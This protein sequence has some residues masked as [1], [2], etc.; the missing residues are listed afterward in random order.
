MCIEEV[1][2]RHFRFFT[3][4]MNLSKVKESVL[5]L[6]QAHHDADGRG[7]DSYCPSLS[8][9]AMAEGKLLA[10]LAELRRSEVV[11]RSWSKPILEGSIRRLFNLAL[12][13]EDGTAFGLGFA[14]KGMPA[15]TPF[16]ITTA[17]VLDGLNRVLSEVDDSDAIRG[18]VREATRWLTSSS[19]LESQT[20]LPKFSPKDPQVVTNVVGYWSYV[21]REIHPELSDAGV[22]HVRNC[23]VGET[24]WPYAAGSERLDLLHT[25]YTIRPLLDSGDF[26]TRIAAAISRFVTPRGLFDKVDAFSVPKAVAVAER[27]ATACV[28]LGENR[29]YVL[30]SAPARGWSIGELLRI[31]A[32]RPGGSELAGF[33]RS[34]AIRS[35]AELENLDLSAEGPRH[36]MHVAHGL[37]AHLATERSAKR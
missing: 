11:S 22:Q 4:A 24:G 27:S 12:L 21:L 9:H 17:I 15:D 25:C 23:Y 33:W 26:A 34:L 18:M 3:P 31:C 29:G 30:H 19:V 6:V 8:A 5:G 36:A 20:G 1:G 16:T 35:L 28:V 7:P 14:W 32:E 13:T 37:A 2:V 10:T